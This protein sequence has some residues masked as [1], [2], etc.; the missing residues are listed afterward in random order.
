MARAQR[1]RYVNSESVRVFKVQ[2]MMHS[3]IGFFLLHPANLMDTM[4]RKNGLSVSLN[5]Q[6][7][8]GELSC[9]ATFELFKTS[10]LL[11]Q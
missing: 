7:I 8:A 5:M 4:P 2:S 11:N 10:I 1:G 3:V 9:V 6:N